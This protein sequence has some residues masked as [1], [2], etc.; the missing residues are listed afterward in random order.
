MF[1]TGV[2]DGVIAPEAANNAKEAS[3]LLTTMALGIPGSTI[4]AILLAVFLMVGITPGL[5]MMVENLPLALT[6]LMG[7]AL[8][9]I[10]G[11]A[12]SLFS[13]PYLARV[14]SVHIDFLFPSVLIVALVGT[15]VATLSIFNFIV[16]FIFGLLGLVMKRY[17][18]SRPAL[19]LGFVLGS[20]FG[21][22]SLLSIKMYGPLFFLRPISLVLIAI[23][24]FILNY[25]YLTKVLSQLRRR[26]KRG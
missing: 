7:I 19:L 24:V 18:Y 15:Y 4:M 23:I 8:A 12:I 3:S 26:F 13:A 9:N 21:N 20:L 1:G 10:V 16:L 14:V 11:G 2:V 22:Y 6:L 5:G 17:G 25:P